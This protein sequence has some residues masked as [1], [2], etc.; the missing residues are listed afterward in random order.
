MQPE[1]ISITSCAPTAP[2][3]SL[4][5]ENTASFLGARNDTKTVTSDVMQ[6]KPFTVR[7]ISGGETGLSCW[8]AEPSNP[9]ARS[10]APLVAVHGIAR[11]AKDHA[12]LLAHSICATGRTVIAPLFYKK[13]WRRYQ[14]AVVGGRA[15]LALLDL[16]TRLETEAAPCTRSAP[17][18]SF[19]LFGFSGGAQFAHRFS[20]LHPHRVRT[21]T[22]ASAGWYTFPDDA[23][24][25]YGF[26]PGQKKAQ[27]TPAAA[28]ADATDWGGK[29]AANLP[30][31][32]NI[33]THVTVGARDCVIDKNTRQG[34]AIDRQQGRTRIG[35][36]RK[37]AS[38]VEKAARTRG[39]PSNVTFSILSGCGHGFAEC[40]RKGELDRLILKQITAASSRVE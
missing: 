2:S 12:T 30:S 13:T 37:W 39:A 5:R 19:H 23:P 36:A 31:L 35:R 3:R 24:F 4:T 7:H 17:D 25:P 38:A 11:E 21:L 15:D 29:M 34:E 8:V 33:P 14:R 40:V 1:M 28:P 22:L 9:P 16:L 20:M 27:T 18:G 26:G 6:K 10:M 32:L